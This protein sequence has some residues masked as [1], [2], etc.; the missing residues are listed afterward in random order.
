MICLEPEAASIYCR[1][2]ETD[3]YSN[4]GKNAKKIFKKK[5]NR[6]VIVDAGGTL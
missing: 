5:G 4:G 1:Q 6:Y 2:L 3:K